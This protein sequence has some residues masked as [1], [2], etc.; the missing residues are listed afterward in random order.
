MESIK[1]SETVNHLSF[2]FGADP[3]PK[4]EIK[5][6]EKVSKQENSTSDTTKN[7]GQSKVEHIGLQED[8]EVKKASEVKDSTNQVTPS[9]NVRVVYKTVG[10]FSDVPHFPAEMARIKQLQQENPVLFETIMKTGGDF[11]ETCG[12]G[13]ENVEALDKWLQFYK[14]GSLSYWHVMKAFEAAC[15]GSRIGT[16]DFFIKNGL[17]LTADIFNGF[18][19][20]FIVEN[21]GLSFKLENTLRFLL[22]NGMDVDQFEKSNYQTP[23]H[24]ACLFK[25]Y[26]VM[27]LLVEFK[28]DV[29]AIDKSGKMPLNYLEGTESDDRILVEFLQ[30]KGAKESWKNELPKDCDW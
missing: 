26:G 28:A 8:T 3:T 1:E 27:K 10:V 9:E 11:I 24:R 13:K 4:Q 21:S 30:S 19:H 23:L 20:K 2:D 14:D 5:N 18:L 12:S 16:M 17:D 15:F 29:N 6:T 22:I 7:A 25:N